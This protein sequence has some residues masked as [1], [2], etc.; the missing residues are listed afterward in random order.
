[1][2]IP[3][4]FVLVDDSV[5]ITLDPKVYSLTAVKK[6]AYRMAD[7][8]TAVLESPSEREL[9]VLFTFKPGTSTTAAAATVR[10]FYQD[11]LDQALRE[12]IAA[13][14]AAVRALILA[15]AFSKTD[16]IRRE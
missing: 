8:C 10:A 2:T 1:M 3:P 5:R 13:E 12:E 6:A 7:R 15:H 4:S 14:T 16:L 9:P 11:V